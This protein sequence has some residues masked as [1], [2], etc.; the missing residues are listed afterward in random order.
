MK[1]K[2]GLFLVLLF[3]F[4]ACGRPVAT[5]SAKQVQ[6]TQTPIA[7]V[8]PTLP[9]K[10]T[11]T[12]DKPIA[13]PSK[14]APFCQPALDIVRPGS[15]VN[16]SGFNLP[17]NRVVSVY[18]GIRQIKTS[19][20]DMTDS[21]GNVN[22]D[23][24][25]PT[26]IALGL[27][28]VSVY[29]EGSFVPADCVIWVW[30]ELNFPSI[31]P[32]LA[33][34][35]E[36][37]LNCNQGVV[38]FS[39]NGQWAVLDCNVDAVTIIHIDETKEWNLSSETLM[40]PYTEHFI[41]VSYWSNDGIYAYI[42]ANPHTDG[43]WEPFH[44]ATTLFRLNLETGQVSEV[45]KGNYYSFSFSPNDRRLA[46]I[47]TDKSPVTLNIR[48]MQTGVEQSFEFE[49]KYNTGGGFVW[50]PDS[51]KLVFTITQF[52]TSIYEYIAT[53]IVL[54]DKE[55]PDTTVLVKGHHETLVP[56]E[57]IDET[58]IILQVLNQED[59]KFEFDLTSGE[60][61]QINP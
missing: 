55:K 32:A 27:Y 33:Q 4:A 31:S 2:A 19:M 50:S 13:V 20:A 37:T 42:S 36:T 54:W 5:E 6:Y 8:T 17:A 14:N 60:L 24:T 21:N 52:D 28:Q 25:I 58:K 44:E 34:R 26:N 16:I 30:P 10:S 15:S 35:L 38:S 45:L 23:I 51:Q 49:P 47:V 56:N 3:F 53:S 46:Y 48:D 9:L 29:A 18:A 39:T 12:P 7:V 22:I 57:W 1:S 41:D 43:Y 40:G 61:K 11:S 59:R